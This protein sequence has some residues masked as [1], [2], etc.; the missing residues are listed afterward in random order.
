MVAPGK[1][2]ELCNI[3]QEEPDEYKND[4]LGQFAFRQSNYS[5]FSFAPMRH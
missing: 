3:I 4:G 1:G 5:C 2:H